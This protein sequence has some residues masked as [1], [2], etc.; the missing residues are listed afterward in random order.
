MFIYSIIHSPSFILAAIVS[1][2]VVK[3][4]LLTILIPHGLRSRTIQ[5]PWLFLLGV[6]IG[7]MFGDIAW[8]VKLLGDIHIVSF[9][10]SVLI[11]FV[12][13]SWSFLII[14]YQS[15]ALFIESLTQ[16]KFTLNPMHKLLF[17]ASGSFALFFFYEAFF[18]TNLTDRMSR[19]AA[20]A[21]SATTAAPFEINAMKYVSF[22]LLQ[23][24]VI[25]GLIST[26][27]NLYTVSL[28][29]ILKKQVKIVLLYFICPY[30]L[31][32]ALQGAQFIFPVFQTHLYGIV[33]CSTILL[34]CA[35][36]YCI[37]ALMGLRFLN[38]ASHVQSAYNRDFI[39]KFKNLLERFSHTNSFHE[40]NALTQTFFYDAFNI[41]QR[42]THLTISHEKNGTT[43]Q[44]LS[45]DAIV[46]NFFHSNHT[47]AYA[48][49]KQRRILI[50]DELEF[51]NFYDENDPRKVL[52][53][54]LENLN[55]DIFLPIY[56]KNNLIAYV[57]VEHTAHKKSL[58]GSSEQDEM[59]IFTRYLGSIINLL[60]HRNLQSLMHKEKELKEE[61]HRKYQEISQYQESIKSFLRDTNHNEM[62]IIFYKNRRFVFGNKAFKNLVP[63]NPNLQEGH[64]ITKVLKK[65]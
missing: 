34:T 17:C 12:R 39:N 53:Q 54:F 16:K 13:L 37:R 42:K 31:V 40:L 41:P 28:P 11:F 46:A 29:T 61:L 36:S 62:G 7:S 23:L 8:I 22:Y 4:Y 6:L 25:P 47:D 50:Y 33:A 10:Y 51:T 24:L 26:F 20:L 65:L 5:K 43:P 56:E 1:S 27:W 3:I 15:L 58:Y 30:L 9:D 64:P 57:I 49:L 44:S 38:F 2:F 63:I 45:S 48:F 55:A 21:L 32:E 19:N 14:Q 52:L 60:Q 18:D 59:L 35:T